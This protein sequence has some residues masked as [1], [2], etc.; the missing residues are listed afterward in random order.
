MTDTTNPVPPET[1]P[2]PQAAGQPPTHRAISDPRE[3]A[4]VVMARMN[5]V[6]A[7]KDELTAAIDGLVDIARQL[8]RTYAEQQL[9][10]EQ[11]RR[12][13]KALEAAAEAPAES[14]PVTL[15]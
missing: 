7:K 13:V 12:R 3:V 5:Q 11:L 2:A 8:T 9:A 1:A 15:N 14:A 4:K 6:N 10:I